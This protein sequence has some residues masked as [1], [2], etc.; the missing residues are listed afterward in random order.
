MWVSR[1]LSDRKVRSI[2]GWRPEH[3][4]N[5]PENGRHRSGK[6]PDRA[7]KASANRLAGRPAPCGKTA[8]GSG[9]PP[10]AIRPDPR[11]AGAGPPR[12]PLQTRD[13]GH[14]MRLYKALWVRDPGALGRTY[15]LA[16]LLP[17]F[18]G[19]WRIFSGAVAHF[20]EQW[21]IDKCLIKKASR[22]G[23]LGYATAAGD[24]AAVSRADGR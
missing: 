12:P 9:Q 8:P 21:G 14:L 18:S 22:S 11:C 10:G 6:W 24:A 20:P 2:G 1:A 13:S 15:I 4:P 7:G 5:A 16:T 23:R 17:N 3:A 19:P